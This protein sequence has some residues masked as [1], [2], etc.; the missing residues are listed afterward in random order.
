MNS[1]TVWPETTPVS[2]PVKKVMSLLLNLLDDKSDNSGDQLAD[3]VFT[4]N[5]YL[6]AAAKAAKGSAGAQPSLYLV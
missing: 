4:P 1:N 5:G 3:E 2:E 6:G